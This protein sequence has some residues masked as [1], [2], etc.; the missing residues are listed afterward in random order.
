MTGRVV[1]MGSKA[2]GHRV[3]GV[4][5]DELRPSDVLAAI[6]CPDDRADARSVLPAFERFAD[7]HGI[8]ITVSADQETASAELWRLRPDFVIVCGWYRII[9][10]LRCPGTA[11][12]GLHAGPLPRYRGGAP[13]VWQIINGERDIGLS[14]FRLAEGPDAGDIVEQGSVPLGV[15]ETVADA[16]YRVED[17]AVR[18]VR[19]NLR[20]ILDGTSPHVPQDHASATTFPSRSPSDGLIDWSLP[21]E[22][23]HDLIRA[24]SAPY[25]GAFTRLADGRTL[26][27]WRSEPVPIAGD[28]GRVTEGADGRPVIGCAEG[29]VRI[30]SA[31]IDREPARPLNELLVAGQLQLGRRATRPSTAA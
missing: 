13:I 1:F 25:P 6:V 21:G 7:E 8:G 29:S 20:G 14:F 17:L 11:F 23:V 10:V 15:L 19:A 31:S 18:L 3:L 5:L 22:R 28:L 12:Y 2:L 4:L 9:P 24:Q 16:L 26:R 30:L 27:I